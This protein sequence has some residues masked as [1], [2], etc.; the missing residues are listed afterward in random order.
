M[1]TVPVGQEIMRTGIYIYIKAHDAH[2]RYGLEGKGDGKHG[3]TTLP[4]DEIEKALIG[5]GSVPVPVVE[6]I[7]VDAVGCCYRL[8]RFIEFYQ[9]SVPVDWA[10]PATLN[11]V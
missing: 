11:M 9:P 3:A 10:P 6:Q 4:D 8:H 2:T 1:V 7:Q 5:F